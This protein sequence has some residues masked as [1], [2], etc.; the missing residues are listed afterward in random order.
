MS[1]GFW[2]T[3]VADVAK[4]GARVGEAVAATVDRA[5]AAESGVVVAAAVGIGVCEVTVVVAP[6]RMQTSIDKAIICAHLKA[7]A[8]ILILSQMLLT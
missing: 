3:C 2:A 5:V 7:L 4:S 1:C 8:N 6:K